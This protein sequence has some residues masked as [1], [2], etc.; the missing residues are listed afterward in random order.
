MNKRQARHIRIFKTRMFA[1]WA[2]RQNLVDAALAF[3]TDEMQRGLIDARLGGHVVKKRVAV[4]GAGKRGSTRT[5]I[6]FKQDEKAFFVYGFAKNERANV[7]K[8]E[9]QALKLLA[10]ELLSYT[11][12]ELA[13]AQLAGELF[14]IE[15]IK[16]G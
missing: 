15:A 16:D 13:R 4:R 8:K 6:A 1:R 3:A 2:A 10:R 14:E 11:A 12:Q 9:L 5:L 7:S